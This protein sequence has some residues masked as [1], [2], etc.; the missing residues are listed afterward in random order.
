MLD[1]VTP[2]QA[3]DEAC[4]ADGCGVP[5]WAARIEGIGN[6]AG[7]ITTWLCQRHYAMLMVDLE[8][9]R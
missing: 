4:R 6:G 1:P 9:G 3:E 5:A 8:A 7:T 2:E